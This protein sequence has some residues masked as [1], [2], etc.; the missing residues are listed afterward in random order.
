MNLRSFSSSVIR[1]T[2]YDDFVTTYPEDITRTEVKN[3]MFKVLFS[4]NEIHDK[5]KTFIPFQ[6]DKEVFSS[7]YPFV[8]ESV[9]ALKVKDNVLLP[10]LL[11]KIESYIFIDCIAKE[12]VDDGIVPLTIHDSLIVKAEHKGR[13][14][15]IINRI[16]LKK[17]K[18]IP[19]FEIKPL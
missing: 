1:G 16:F 2:L 5:Y 9:K 18:A 13:T 8:Y 15:E 14:T 12:L 4:K 7:I 10:V 3:I 19:A 11:Q 17:F 6:K